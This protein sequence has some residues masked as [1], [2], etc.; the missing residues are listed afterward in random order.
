LA[1]KEHVQTNNEME[2]DP[3]QVNGAIL[4]KKCPNL[5]AL[6]PRGI[7]HRVNTVTEEPY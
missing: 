4:I 3:E 1:E 2:D 6:K 5:K 7:L